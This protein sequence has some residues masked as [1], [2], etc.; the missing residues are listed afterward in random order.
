VRGCRGEMPKLRFI[1][2]HEGQCHLLS[3]QTRSMDRSMSCARTQ[4]LWGGLKTKM[5]TSEKRWSMLTLSQETPTNLSI[6][7]YP[8][9][10]VSLPTVSLL[11]RVTKEVERVHQEVQ[12]RFPSRS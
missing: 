9:K 11:S 12:P 8:S 1:D 2:V 7:F 4:L 5:K 10:Q 3:L 6:E